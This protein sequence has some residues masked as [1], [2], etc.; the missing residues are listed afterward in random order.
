ME[1]KSSIKIGK[2]ELSNPIMPAS[3][4][5]GYGIEFASFIDLNKLGA[6]VTK[7]LSIDENIGNAPPRISE[8]ENGLINSIGL[9]NIGLNKFI[10]EVLPKLEKLKTKLIVSFFGKTKEEFVEFV[11]IADKIERIDAFEAN[12][13]CPNVKYNTMHYA[14]KT[15]VYDLVSSVRRYATKP[16]LVKLSPNITDIKEIARAS[17]D[18]GCDGLVI[19]NTV[20]G[21]KYLNGKYFFGGVSGK[22]LKPIALRLIHEIRSILNVPIIGCGGIFN[23]NDVLEYLKTGACAVQIGTANFKYPDIMIKLIDNLM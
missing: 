19:C 7:S 10:K 14:K 11:K 17:F 23:K 2:L 18:A 22:S 21:A 4:T 3:G 16:L 8:I 1:F 13:S 9:E 20:K 6:I 15:D 12:L 5:F